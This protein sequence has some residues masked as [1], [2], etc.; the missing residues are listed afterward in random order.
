[1]STNRQDYLLVQ[2]PPLTRWPK[3]VFVRSQ[4]LAASLKVCG[5]VCRI[6]GGTHPCVYR[7]GLPE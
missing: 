7:H 6:L 4:T 5:R 2:A 3:P 1:M